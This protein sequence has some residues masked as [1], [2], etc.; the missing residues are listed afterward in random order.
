MIIYAFLQ[1]RKKIQKYRYKTL[2]NSN[3]LSGVKIWTL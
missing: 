2:N 1:K 3:I